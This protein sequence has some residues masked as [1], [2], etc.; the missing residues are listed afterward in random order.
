MSTYWVVLG[1]SDQLKPFGG[2]FVAFGRFHATS[3][4]AVALCRELNQRVPGE[5]EFEVA[6]V[7]TQG[8]GVEE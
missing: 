4:E 7:M 6:V 3:D 5:T 1:E 2:K 8:N